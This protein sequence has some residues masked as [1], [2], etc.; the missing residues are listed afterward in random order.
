MGFNSKYKG[1][2][3]EALLDKAGKSATQQDITSAKEYSKSLLDNFKEEINTSPEN[4]FPLKTVNGQ[5]LYGSGNIIVAGGEGGG[6]TETTY[7]LYFVNY[8]QSNT[9]YS[10]RGDKAELKFSFV[11]MVQRVGTSFFV[12]T[13]ESGKVTISVK[14]A[15]E[16]TFK[17]VKTF[18]APPN[19]VQN[20]DVSPYIGDGQ[21]S[22][23]I[24][25]I[26][27][28]TGREADV[29]AYTVVQSSLALSAPNFQ[30][31]APQVGDVTIP[32]LVAGSLNKN[33]HV[34]VT[35]PNSYIREYIS[36]LGTTPYTDVAFSQ[37]IEHPSTSGVYTIEAYVASVDGNFRTSKITHQVIFI[38]EGDTGKYVAV[39][40]V[41]KQAINYSENIIF[42]YSIYNG[43]NATMPIT[44]TASKEGESIYSIDLENVATGSKNTFS[45][46]LEVETKDSNNFDIAIFADSNGLNVLSP[47]LIGVDNRYSFAAFPG[48]VFHLNPKTR[49]NSQSNREDIINAVD[50]SAIN[51]EW[52]NMNWGSDGYQTING[53]KV[54]RLL[55]GSRVTID[56][57]PF[58]VESSRI[59]RTIELDFTI[60]NVVDYESTILEITKDLVNSWLG[61]K[62]YPDKATVFTQLTHS[63]SNQSLKFEDGTRIV[64]TIVVMPNAYGNPSFNLVV[65]YVNGVKNRE[66]TYSNTDSF[67]N[68]GSIVIGSD[69][70]DIDL[71]TS[72]IYNRALSE[73]AVRQNYTN[74][75]NTIEEKAEFQRKN[76]VF[77]SNGIDIDIEK[78]KKLCNVIVFEGEMPSLANPNKFKNNWHF[79]WKD[80]P[81]WNCVV[82][83]ITQD[84]QGTSAKKYRE[85][86]QRGKTSS[87]TVTT[88]ANGDT[89]TGGFVFI[90][91]MPIVEVFTFKLNWASAPQCNKMGSVNSLNDVYTALD[92]LDSDNNPVAIYQRPFVG[93]QLTYD[94]SGNPIYIFTGLYTGGPDKGDK[95]W[96]N[97]DY[98]KYPNLISVEGADNASA[99]A[100]FKV[101]MN[102]TSGR[103]QYNTTEE[104]FQYNGENAFDYNAGAA[105]TKEDIER[106][107]FTVFKPIYD[108]IYECSPNLTYWNGTIEE[109]NNQVATYRSKDTEFWLSNG[110]V[111]YYES[112]L[113]KYIPS[114]FD[115]GTVNLFTQL[116]DK[117]YGLTSN[118]VNSLTKEELNSRFI[119]A[120]INKFKLESPSK[121]DI[122]QAKKNVNWMEFLGSTDTRA[123]NTYWTVRG[124]LEDGYL[125]T[126]YYDDTDTIGPFNN[127]GQDT[128]TYYCEVGD[129]YGDGSPVW[130]GE[131]SRFFNLVEEAFKEELKE[132]MREMLNT[133]TE[134]SGLNTGNKSSQLFAFFHK[135]YF[136]QAQEYFPQALYNAAAKRLY[137]SAKIVHG[138]EYNNDT[139]PITQS[140][141]DYYSGWKRWIKR[142]IQYIQSKYSFG[143]YSA[144]GGDVI[145]VRAAG[146]EI[147]YTLTPA[148]WMYPNIASGTSIFRADRTPA[149][150]PKIMTIDLG[151]S[152]D[153]QNDIK[154]ANWLQSIGEWYN[155]NVKGTMSVTGRMLKELKLGHPTEDITIS[156]DRLKLGVTPSLRDIDLRRISTLSDV[157]DLQ[158]CTHLQTLNAQGTS[159]TSILLPNGGGVSYLGFPSTL[160]QVFLRNYPLLTNSNV[161][162]HECMPGITD[163]MVVGC[164]NMQPFKM[165]SYIINAQKEQE[166]H[167]LK[168][169]RVTD[170]NESFDDASILTT[171]SSLTD[172]TYSGLNAEGVGIGEPNPILEGKIKI[173]GN[174]Y[175]DDYNK[176]KQYFP[177]LAMEFLGFYVAIKDPEVL[178]VLME[179]IT[180]DDGIGLTIEDIEGV[181]SIGTWFKGNTIIETFDE[182]ENFIGITNLAGNC[183]NAAF[184]LCS[185]L[186]SIKLPNTITSMGASSFDG[187]SS[188]EE[189]TIPSGV[190]ALNQTVLRNCSSLHTLD[191]DWSKITTI[192]ADAFRGCSALAI[193]ELNLPNLTTLG[194]NAFY[195]V[196]IKKLVF[197]SVVSLPTTDSMTSR[198]YGDPEILEEVVLPEGITAIPKI[199]FYAYKKLSKCELPQSVIK[200]G[201]Q[202]FEE[203]VSLPSIITLDN[204]QTLSLRAY[205]YNSTLEEMHL[206]SIVTIAD[207]SNYRGCFTG[208]TNLR[209]LHIG[210]NCTKIG[211][212][213]RSYT[214]STVPLDIVCEAVTPPTLGSSL[215][216]AGGVMGDIYVPD[217]SVEAY[218]QASNWSAFAS[219]IY[220]MSV[221]ENGGVQNVI[222]FADPAVEA[223]VLANWDNGDGYFMKSEAEAV[224]SIGSKFR[225]KTE[226]TSFD[227]LRYFVNVDTLDSY[228][229]YKCS[230]LTSIGL[231]NIKTLE[232]Y[233]LHITGLSGEIVFNSVESWGR[234]VVGGTSVTS[235]ILPRVIQI[236]AGAFDGLSTLEVVDIGENCT[237]IGET[238]WRSD[239]A[240][241]SI[242][243]RALTPPSLGS[244][245][246]QW[247]N[248]TFIIYVP[249]AAVDTYKEASGWSDASVVNRI[250][251]LSEYNG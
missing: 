112:S 10:S 232:A 158:G 220:P 8:S 51:A 197:G 142:R 27:E 37:N 236:S 14:K 159:L 198:T 67:E 218:K 108:F 230:A 209:L 127:Q 248:N 154:G 143:D 211:T 201:Q 26:G 99:G 92:I 135:Y 33:L 36:Q 57:K 246:F 231:D 191:V 202:A 217:E 9:I 241:R 144:N 84:G 203:C 97:W 187:C 240:L 47:I 117:G 18:I 179:K 226:I 184:Y 178:R 103:W 113:G 94:D 170:I 133:M 46:A 75:L 208:C 68:N 195:G 77:A 95:N 73:T 1:S 53:V 85:W 136:S 128:K 66:F 119:Q 157:L 56:Y 155:K 72:R 177:N 54:L 7:I 188:L 60:D 15:S 223:I 166:N 207:G 160:Q 44:F 24:T 186:K 20:I 102:T 63:E 69:S 120:R 114:D 122:R 162:I 58:E 41:I 104:S 215:F 148:I 247:T 216:H 22:I 62:L 101:P 129:K 23:K 249:D 245:A 64:L 52:S 200:I 139:D 224:T 238:A 169:I 106:L 90:P 32:Y 161:D 227:E 219:R 65:L 30:W 38:T 163:F 145:S 45:I 82:R 181:T 109:L 39:N 167:A 141:G 49:D 156:I 111:Y 91:G 243:V 182:F 173:G 78:V 233:A 180:T 79:F 168:R 70:A 132:S 172:G 126:F 176:L 193:E 242:V 48:A 31:W 59:G 206:P 164:K 105:E 213:L 171:I 21:N 146:N 80:N 74:L 185:N 96:M 196:K 199:A 228:S 40:N 175:E 123:K 214:N 189:L 107:F 134:L 116:V 34:T 35:G 29:M 165:L 131:Q 11:S 2:E 100:L 86:N 17:E 153:Q 125:L 138:T 124:L 88:Y 137:E 237:S 225:E 204:V 87:S 221:Y 194:A 147:S 251:P 42:D 4:Y 183:Q 16:D 239:S 121:I 71:H 149:G 140:L 190:T 81:E 61:V 55:S 234:N 130:N 152:A 118:D 43:G 192:G 244:N 3:V 229:F 205:A 93:F 250:K 13:G 25:A 174:I 151:G 210:P 212:Y 12:D 222:T 235:I 19:V 98:E 50:N 110:D 6:A 115:Y 76:D 89:T 83:N 150:Q 5:T 28:I